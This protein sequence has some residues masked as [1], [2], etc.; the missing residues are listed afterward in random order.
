MEQVCFWASGASKWVMRRVAWC[1][2]C[3]GDY[4][5]L[6]KPEHPIAAE[7]ADPVFW[8]FWM[9]RGAAGAGIGVIDV[10]VRCR[11]PLRCM[12][13]GALGVGRACRPARSSGHV[14]SVEPGEAETS[15]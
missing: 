6:S 10:G 11:R 13:S 9:L 1:G 15:K 8:C 2:M 5:W 3:L 12:S 14:I 4:T 7:R